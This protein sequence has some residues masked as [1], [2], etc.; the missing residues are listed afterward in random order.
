MTMSL[1]YTV[2]EKKIKE[3]CLFSL[4]MDTEG[5]KKMRWLH[6]HVKATVISKDKENKDQEV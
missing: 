1:Q 4:Q 3:L 2:Y 6:K 5:K